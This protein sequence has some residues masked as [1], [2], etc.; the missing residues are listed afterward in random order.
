MNKGKA[1]IFVLFVIALFLAYEVF[2]ATFSATLTWTAP[3]TWSDGSPLTTITGYNVYYGAT[4]GGPYPNKIPVGIVT[5]TTINNIVVASGVVTYYFTVT[6]LA[7]NGSGTV[8]ESMPSNEA[9]KTF[10]ARTPLPPN[11]TNVTVVEVSLK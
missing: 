10:D 8:I 5:S 3:T 2:A 6:T 1:I 4:S 11:L 7:T 9:A